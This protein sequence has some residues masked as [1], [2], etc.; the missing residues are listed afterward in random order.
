MKRGMKILIAFLILT[1]IIFTVFLYAWFIGSK[2]LRV[3]EYKIEVDNLP[4]E[5]HGLKIAHITDIHY[6]ESI[7][8]KELEKLK[9]K[10][11]SL[12]PDIIVFT[13]DISTDGLSNKHIE[14]VSEI[15]SQM[16]AS[17][18]KYAIKGNH[19]YNFK[20]WDLLFDNS[21]FINLNDTYDT[22]Y[23]NKTIPIIISG[24]STNLYGTKNIK[25][26]IEPI[27]E[28]LNSYNIESSKQYAYSI[29]LLHEP[30]FVKEI[31]YNKFDMVLAGHSHNG[32]VRLPLIGAI[33]T[34]IGSKKYYDEYYKLNNTDLYISSGV[35]TTLLNIRLFNKPSFN[36]YRLTTK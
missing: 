11:N 29:L 2:G 33:Y 30:D 14:E 34:P 19:D 23:K 7:N 27:Y 24:I 35:G 12:K 4:E 10:I 17:I 20:K 13:G 15:M 3:K 32:Q 31:D 5:Y 26:K 8:K 21:G 16:E 9:N 6:G 1:G 25:D 36:F 28:N 18:G 22:I